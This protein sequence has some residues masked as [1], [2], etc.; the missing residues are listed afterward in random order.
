M[1]DRADRGLRRF[2]TGI[3][4]LDDILGGGV[5]VYAVVVLAGEPGTGKT[6]LAQQMLFANAAAGR[7]GLYLTT[8]SESPIK[9]A[10]YQSSFT[11]FDPDKFGESVVYM[12][13]GETIRRHGLGQ[14]VEVIADALRANQPDMVVIDSFRAI[15]DLAAEPG[16]VRTFVYDLAVELSAI[17]ATSFLVGEYDVGDLADMAEF[18]VAD[19]IIWLS[20]ERANAV[21][22]RFLRVLKMRGVKHQTTPFSFTISG[23]GIS[24]YAL[25]EAGPSTGQ[26][27][28]GESAVPTGVPGLDELLRGGI[29]AG[30][31]L[32]V[33]GQAG[34]GKTTLGMQYLYHGALDYGEKGVYFSYEEAPEQILRNASRFGWD[35][36][37]LVG[38]GQLMIYHT[39]LPAINPDAEI[40]NIRKTIVE[41][42]ARRVVV[43]SLTM[44]MHGIDDPD[45]VRRQVYSLAR[46]FRE[47]GCAALLITDPPVGSELISRFGVEESI[48]DGV[49]VLRSVREERDRRRYV[50]IYKMRGVNHAT[51]DNLVRITPEGIRVFPRTE[52]AIG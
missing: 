32:L 14:A 1:S 44:L 24:L 4:P 31:P 6:I 10:R 36:G 9:T 46:V 48:L 45:I 39:P 33:S 37:R 22:R 26:G 25:P 42:G 12:D 34:T 2:S 43:D 30:S 3:P 16:E 15:H 11:F 18:A 51:G 35:M 27:P 47:A 17:Q 7:K 19:G 40:V 52:E 21:T 13:I 49:L 5:P 8:L 20:L 50:E 38:Q 41:T 23:D 29:P 28:A